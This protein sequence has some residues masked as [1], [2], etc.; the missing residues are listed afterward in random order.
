[1]L[2]SIFASIW[3]Q[4]LWDELILKNQINILEEKYWKDTKFI[5]FSYDKKNP[6]F[7]K[8]NVFYKNYFPIW[9]RNPLNIFK[10]IISYISFLHHSSRSDL[11]IIWWWW[12]IYDNE[13][14]VNKSPLD[15]WLFRVKT[16]DFFRKKYDF[17]RVSVDIKNENNLNKLKR[18][19][20]KANNISVRDNQS[21]NLLL[22]N[23]I[24]SN[25]EI[26]PVFFDKWILEKKSSIVWFNSSYEFDM[27]FLSIFDL[28]DKNVWL[29]LRYW[30]M[31]EKSKLSDRLEEWK[32]N[33]LIHTLLSMWAKVVL[34][35]HSFH[36]TDSVA[37]DYDYLKT[38]VKDWVFLKEDMKE[39]YEVYTDK[40]IDFCISMRL[41]SM[42]LC[43][44]YNIPFYAL[45]Y[46][47]KTEEAVTYVKSL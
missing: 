10:N 13:I 39:T 3:S 20:K 9:V 40:D 43:N 25:V 12:I 46:S 8:D 24:N 42:I 38:F 34:L 31:F 44:V 33:Q 30:Y 17:F 14:Q 45:S 15:S 4:N 7:K 2:I 23:G 41:H 37:N 19:F 32:I 6:F 28:K 35:P 1:M 18:I 5:V 22:E 47:N 29:S 21:Y 36:K 11:I 16:F 27:S 26:D